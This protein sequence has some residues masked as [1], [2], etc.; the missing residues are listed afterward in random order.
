MYYVYVSVCECMDN[1]SVYVCMYNESVCVCVCV[2]VN[3]V[4]VR[5][6]QV[7]VIIPRSGALRGRCAGLAT[8]RLPAC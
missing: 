5:V 1:M 8:S 4:C 6:L 7:T 2:C 3:R